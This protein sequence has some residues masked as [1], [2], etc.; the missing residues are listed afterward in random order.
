[1]RGDEQRVVDAFCAYLRGEG[2]EVSTEVEYADVVATRAGR[3]LYA[4]AKGRTSEPGTDA[5]TMYGQLLRRMGSA[6]NPASGYAVVVP[7]TAVKAAQ[8]VPTWVRAKLR[9]DLY[10]VDEQGR[11]AL[12]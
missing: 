3:A 7:V 6:D 4:E 5:D 1:M 9:I 8:R 11:V 10:V 12:V 2:W